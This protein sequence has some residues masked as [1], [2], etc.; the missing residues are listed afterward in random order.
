MR[1]V[2]V[3]LKNLELITPLFDSYR[4]FYGQVSDLSVAREF[5]KARV[6]NEQSIIFLAI[7]N[8]DKSVGFTQLYPSFSSVS[9]ARTWILNDLYVVEEARK[10][11]VAKMLMNAAREL[12]V[13]DKVK[14]LVLETA[15]DNI[16]AQCLY[17]SLG[18]EKELG[19]YHY[20]LN[21]K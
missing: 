1:I 12:A 16:T 5:I 18:Y 19:I 20:F 15:A 11:G 3:N 14:G 8:N 13:N 17:E 10:Q 7:D 21:L 9:V 6:E 4:V 2:K